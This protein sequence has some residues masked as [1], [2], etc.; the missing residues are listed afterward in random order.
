M[1]VCKCPA[2][3]KAYKVR[4]ELA[5]R[6]AKCACGH[7]FII[8]APAE[9]FPTPPPNPPADAANV[10][11]PPAPPTPPAPEPAAPPAKPEAAS[12]EPSESEDVK[13]AEP[14]SDVFQ[15]TAPDPVAEPA[16][17][18]PADAPREFTPFKPAP[19]PPPAPQAVAAP[20]VAASPA[21]AEGNGGV[22]R[23]VFI[24]AL[25][26]VTIIAAVLGMMARHS[27]TSM[28]LVALVWLIISAAG[29]FVVTQAR[30]LNIG[31]NEWLA[32]LWAVPVVNFL[33]IGGCSAFP[34]GFKPD[35]RS[36]A[37]KKTGAAAHIAASLIIGLGFGAACVA[38]AYYL[39]FIA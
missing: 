6:S 20:A 7:R 15:P 21:A 24:L 23:L 25:V 8:P 31:Y 2:C 26:F 37:P 22:G 5:G 14:E 33:L 1:I 27:G 10:A 32:L 19:A 11:P 17:A 38:F 30:L 3:S 34:E 4:D 29:M 18:P 13:P 16:P 9:P 36:A 12:A 35:R 28:R 39:L